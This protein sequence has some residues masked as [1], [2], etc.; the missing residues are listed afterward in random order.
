MVL[1][2]RNEK[3]ETLVDIEIYEKEDY[4]ELSSIIIIEPYSKLLLTQKNKEQIIRDFEFLS[5]LR[6]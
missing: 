1:Y 6:G 2:L 3:N 5:E 4:V